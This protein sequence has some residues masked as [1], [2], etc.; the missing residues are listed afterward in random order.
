MDERAVG[1]GAWT[2]A[3]W[4]SK[5]LA[6]EVADRKAQCS[7]AVAVVRS[8][9]EAG[10]EYHKEAFDS[11]VVERIEAPMVVDCNTALGAPSLVAAGHYE[12]C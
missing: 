6:L 10:I 11:I 1:H 8:S 2:V 3:V 9:A 5:E 12:I 4:R 7:F